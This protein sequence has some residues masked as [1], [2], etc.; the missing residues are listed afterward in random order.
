[1]PDFPHIDFLAARLVTVVGSIDHGGSRIGAPLDDRRNRGRDIVVDRADR[2]ADDGV[3]EGA[4]ALLELAHDEHPHMG[5]LESPLHAAE[6][7][8]QIGSSVGGGRPAADL[9]ELPGVVDHGTHPWARYVRPSVESCVSSLIH[10][11]PARADHRPVAYALGIDLGTTYTAAALVEDG[12]IRVAD[13]GNRA[14]VIPSVLFVNEDGSVLVGDAA[15]RRA[16]SDPARV[17][18]EFKRRV[19]DPTAILLGGSPWS[20]EALMGRLLRWTVDAVTA[21]E[22]SPPARIALCRPANWGPYKQ[23][24]LRDAIRI[25]EV[26]V[27]VQLTE[28]EA[29]AISY[30]S[31]EHVPPDSVVAV[32]DLGGGTFDAAVLRRGGDG[33]GVLGEP[34][35]I[36]RLG[37]I[38]FD[39]AVF[40]FV[41]EALGP[42]VG[43]LDP[44]DPTILTAIARLRQECVEAKEALSADTE[45]VIPVLLPSMQTEVRITRAEFEAM[46]RPRVSDTIAALRR[47]LRSARV[48]PDEVGA[49]LLVGGSS[50][51]PAGRRARGPR[52]RPPRCR[53]RPPQAH[54]G[55]GSGARRGRRAR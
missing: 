42:A 6:P 2:G 9:H 31:T 37:G 23:D 49:V 40:G 35:G 28:P 21:A 19:G 17:A 46:I 13:L 22:G 47:A 33:F 25:A 30:T 24:L 16:V 18:R 36:E 53:R 48:E 20:A 12:Q 38:D 45:T 34:E 52:A 55:Q 43:E 44:H 11:P 32:Y 41:A 3:D 14:P 8:V 27:H 54:G 7:L 50:R 4:F 39:Q 26:E 1:M 51:I 15:N 5:V 29:A 10:R